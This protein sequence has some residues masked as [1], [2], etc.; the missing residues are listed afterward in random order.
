MA[1][2]QTP[3]LTIDTQSDLGA[4]LRLHVAG[5]PVNVFNRQVL[6]DL[7]S[8]LDRLV[9]LPSLKLLGILSAKSTGF[10]AGADL[11]EFAAV[12][13]AAEATTLS[14]QG[15][16]LMDKLA[17]LPVP[18]AAVIAGPCLGGGLEFALACDYRLVIDHPKTQLGLPEIELGLLPGWGGTQRLPHVIG[19]EPALRV[20]LGGRRLDAR[21]ALAWGLADQVV[22]SQQ[23][24]AAD[25]HRFLEHALGHGKRPREGLPLRTWR[26]RLLESTGLGRRLIFR[27]SERVLR[28]RVPDDMPAPREALEAVRVGLA[29]GM[30]AGLAYER[31]AIGRLAT[32]PAC[33]NLVN[34]FFQRERARKEAEATEAH[35]T[36]AESS[37][38]P[39]AEVPG[40]PP[41][42]LGVIGAGTMGAGIAQ[43]AAIKGFDVVVREVNESAL[44]A[45]M[46]RIEGLFRKAV[47]RRLLSEEEA[48]QKLAGMG[49]TTAWEG[50]GDVAVV[51][52][53]AVEDLEAKRAIFR[54]LEQHTPPTAV[55][56]TNTSS[57]SVRQLQEGLRHPERV[58]GLHF[59]NPVHKMPL[60]EVVRAP[61]TSAETAA[62]LA[63]WAAALGKT[64][65]VVQDSPGFVVNRILM[66]YL[67]EAVLL[68]VDGMPVDRIDAVMRRFGMPMGPLELLDQV[69]LDVAAHI[70]R[71]LQ[72]TF[73]TR[74]APNAVFDRM[75][76]H[77][78]LGQKN[79][80]GFY[81]YRGK[82]KTVH[83]A[84]VALLRGDGQTPAAGVEASEARARMVGLMLNE[85]AACLAERLAADA[86]TIDLALVLGT[87]WAP[88]RGGPLRYADDRG[89]AE[90]VRVLTDLARR[91][92]PRFEPCAELRRHA[93]KGE[94][95]YAAPL[96]A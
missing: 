5:R 91:L 37:A 31:E 64:P 93:E 43:L 51:V 7:D 4:V 10:I 33:R 32:S 42:R 49:R 69:G 90:V 61:A 80:A 94:P 84:A 70:A 39:I 15:Q 12:R 18:T 75:V 53:A 50:F 40:P 21:E 26:Q 54:E 48:R 6:A 86:A 11:H 13:S 36:A 23:S 57:L 9:A 71:S 83:A 30:D 56:A 59:F 46:Q 72:P 92:G 25:L 55:L 47:E 66:P 79:R 89:I 85:A 22:T 45:G 81:R 41:R 29:Q 14:A 1:F 73:G 62:T 20:I 96:A 19:L 58:G 82:A 78:W 52:E 68:A 67:N 16:R 27:G 44:A 35:G 60:V 2:F 77:G 87:G 63:Q 65:V 34:L 24:Y 76:E 88:H 17:Y 95:F 74:F 38:C 8:A 28:R 3:N